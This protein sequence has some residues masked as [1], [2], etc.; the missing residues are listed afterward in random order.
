MSFRKN[1]LPNLV[2]GLLYFLLGPLI[3]K[4]VWQPWV[5]RLLSLPL[6]L[7]AR[8]AG[9]A[10]GL[11]ALLFGLLH[12][13]AVFTVIGR[14]YQRAALLF[15]RSGDL[16]PREL[17]AQQG[18]QVSL[19]M[20]VIRAAPGAPSAPDAPTNRTPP[21]FPPGMASAMAATDQQLEAIQ[22]AARRWI[23][24]PSMEAARREIEAQTAA[25]T[26]MWRQIAEPV[27]ADTTKWLN[28]ALLNLPSAP[29]S[30]TF[31]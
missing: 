4:P 1:W 3:F 13:R 19:S 17:S 10:V 7:L 2:T 26:A 27:L 30:L 22:S 5:E 24:I 14:L 21:A 11:S 23:D 16:I 15:R 18:T 25:D 29:T 6:E 9:Y 28:A 31:S 12:A 8:V 20:R